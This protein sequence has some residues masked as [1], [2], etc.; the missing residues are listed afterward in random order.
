MN[1]KEETEIRKPFVYSKSKYKSKVYY[2]DRFDSPWDAAKEPCDNVNCSFGPT[3]DKI[4]HSVIAIDNIIKKYP[5][6]D[7]IVWAS[8]R[9][10]NQTMFPTLQPPSLIRKKL[11]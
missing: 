6:D 7:L 11:N 8:P 1:S 3:P 2:S 5:H 9:S 4:D 10:T